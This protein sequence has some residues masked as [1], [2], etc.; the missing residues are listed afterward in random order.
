[1]SS[2]PTFSLTTTGTMP[3]NANRNGVPPHQS[4]SN[5]GT[6]TPQNGSI[7]QSS[8]FYGIPSLRSAWSGLVRSFSYDDSE[9]HDHR[10]PSSIREIP[11]PDPVSL[12]GWKSSTKDAS[13][14]MTVPLA[15]EIK[16]M[17]PERLQIVDGWQLVY[18]LVQD[19]TLLGTLY[20]KCAQ[21]SEKRRGQRIGFVVVVRDDEGGIF[22]AYMSDVPHIS[23]NYF[24]NGECFLWRA[25][26]QISL[27]PPPSTDTTKMARN[28]MIA[29]SLKKMMS[30]SATTSE[31][32]LGDGDEEKTRGGS[33]YMQN[34]LR[35]MVYPYSGKNDYCMLCE[36]GFL[37]LGGG[38][39]RY[40]LW[41]NE[42]L[43]MGHSDPCPTYDND[44]LSDQGGKFGILGVEVWAIGG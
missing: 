11:P 41:M 19:G 31:S 16:K 10:L 18:S 2:N 23:K 44:G 27:P 13:R 1:M 15:E 6:T 17:V 34:H 26:R 30:T 43:S 12:S 33:G 8:S 37:S 36:P 20:R 7:S 42:N 9:Q 32:S 21:F 4:S 5:S 29:P 38:N 22:G 28:T 24:G 14:V 40:G 25:S 3:I 39:G 35:F